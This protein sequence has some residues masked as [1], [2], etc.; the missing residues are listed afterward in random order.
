MK[1]IQA[2]RSMPQVAAPEQHHLSKRAKV[3]V[4]AALMIAMFVG[5]LDQTIVSTALPTIVGDLD[6]VDQML[7]VTTAYFLAS[8]I[9]MPIYGKLGDMFGRK[10]LFEGALLFFIGG[11]LCSAVTGSM[12]GLIVGRAI[13]GLGGGGL[14][15]L[16]Q[17]TI[18]DIFPPKERGKYMGVMGASFGVSMAIGPLLGGLFTEYLSWRWCFW[19]NIP[20]GAIALVAM[21]VALPH[22]KRK[23]PRMSEIDV[24][25]MVVLAAACTCFV[26]AISLGGTAIPL[27]TPAF[28]ALVAGAVVLAV[29]FVFV[30][31]RA[32]EPV[33]P[34][35]LFKNRNFMV[36]TVAG[37][38]IMV[39][40]SGTIAYL[41]TY[42]QIVDG[43]EATPAGYMIIP[44][45]LAMMVTSIIAGF[46]ASKAKTVKWMPLLSC[47]VT[48]VALTWF[49]TITI[50]TSLLQLAIMLAFLGFGVGIGQQILVLIVQNEFPVSMVG[51]ATAAN[52]FFR[53][54]GG[55]IGGSAVGALFTSS[56]MTQLASNLGD[57]AAS[58]N[59]NG[60]TP[61]LVRSMDEPLRQAIQISY[62]DAL[63]PVFGLLVPFLLVAFVLL[64]FLKN[65]PLSDTNDT[66]E[67]CASA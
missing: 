29:V 32:K 59:A 15:I 7:W 19:I 60:L 1:N 53:Q 20:L 5:S 34:L 18:A 3:A 2:N 54:T 48:A 66:H 35:N 28:A 45:M 21:A 27:D 37:L 33:I 22:R 49:A 23:S 56:L 38:V 55:T 36:C 31:L 46:V 12:L 52:N 50:D 57:A 17:A 24:P 64:L 9:T 6:A 47:A 14:M 65:K 63:A 67:T 42:F 25:G 41:P 26:L 43:L 8:T 39:A 4:F 44:L 40:M 13:Q 61:Q 10:R 11:S 62:N 58:I 51:T 30:E 16:S